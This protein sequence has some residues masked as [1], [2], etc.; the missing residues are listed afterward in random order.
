MVTINC[1]FLF[2]I[3]SYKICCFL[4]AFIILV[5]APQKLI[6]TLQKIKETGGGKKRGR[7]GDEGEEE[8]DRYLASKNGKKSNKKL[9]KR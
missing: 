1:P 7:G 6:G 4:Y 8:I 5:N 3:L 2:F 9:K